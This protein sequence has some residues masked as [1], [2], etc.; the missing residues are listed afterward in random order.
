MIGKKKTCLVGCVVTS[1]DPAAACSECTGSGKSHTCD[2]RQTQ[3]TNDTQTTLGV[4]LH[5]ADVLMDLMTTFMESS[6]SNSPLQTCQ[7]G[8]DHSP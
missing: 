6:E 4:K 5:K 7:A 1:E 8:S 3:R 2:F